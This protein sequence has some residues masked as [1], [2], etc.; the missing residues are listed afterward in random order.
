MNMLGQ[1][2]KTGKT[3]ETIDVSNLRSGIYFLE[4]NDGD[5]VLIKKFIKK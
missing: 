5:E 1:T 2:I 4:V 3:S